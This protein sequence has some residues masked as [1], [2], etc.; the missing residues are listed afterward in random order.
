MWLYQKKL[1]YPV[2]I[3]NPNPRLAK[4]IISQYGGPNG[5]I[6]ASMRYI[7]QRIGMPDQKSKAILND[8]GTEELAHLEMVSTMVHQLTDGVSPEELEKA[9]LG[10]YYTDHG[11]GTYPQ[12]ASGMAFSAQTL[13]VTGDPIAD[14]QEDLAAD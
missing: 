2:N 4:F 1:E 6:G 7:S 14:L 13:Q 9:G 3:K 12:S 8:V 5:E 11:W 10:D